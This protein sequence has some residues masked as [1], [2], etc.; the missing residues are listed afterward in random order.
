[1]GWEVGPAP[2]AFNLPQAAQDAAP[3]PASCAAS[4][5]VSGGKE[6]P[7]QFAGE[8]HLC[9]Q[10]LCGKLQGLTL[11]SVGQFFPPLWPRAA[12]LLAA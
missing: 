7:E 8:V 11:L 4:P 10:V 6:L 3:H 5:G 2:C 12:S 9:S 1:M